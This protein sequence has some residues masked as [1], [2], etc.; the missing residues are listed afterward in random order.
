[1]DA[2]VVR[3]V[4]QFFTVMLDLLERELY[5]VDEAL[6]FREGQSRVVLY[7][8]GGVG[9]IWGVVAYAVR[10]Y[11]TLMIE[12]FI[13]P[14]KHFPVVVVADKLMLTSMPQILGVATKVFSPL[15]A[16]FGG[17]LAWMTMFFSPSIFGFLAWELRE[18]YKLYRA[19]R[20]EG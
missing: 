6:R 10:F 13:N 16:F 15:G 3:S 12:P 1:M 7:L 5:R 19:T 9:L 17:F 11:V 4:G 2:S 20:G 8:K 14:L 18:N